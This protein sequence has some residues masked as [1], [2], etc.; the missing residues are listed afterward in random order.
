VAVHGREPANRGGL[1]AWQQKR[2]AAYIEEHVAND[3]PLATLAELC[4]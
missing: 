1:A 4:S 3:I 2:V